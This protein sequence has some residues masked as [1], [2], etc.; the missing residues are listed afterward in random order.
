MADIIQL[1]IFLIVLIISIIFRKE[2]KKL[3][4]W[5]VSFRKVTKNEK[6]FS[7]NGYS[8]KEPK[9]I[10]PSKL[11]SKIAKTE[12]DEIKKDEKKFNF[13]EQY[14]LEQYDELI[15]KLDDLINMTD[16]NEQ[17]I[18]YKSQKCMVL[19]SV[20]R[21]KAKDYYIEL[22]KL[23]PTNY[24]PY[25]YYARAN[26][27]GDKTDECLSILE[28]GLQNVL[29]KA[30]L[31]TVKANCLVTIGD[32]ENAKKILKE[33]IQNNTD[34]PF[35]FQ[36]L[37]EI[38]DDKPQI[39]YDWFKIGVDKFPNDISLRENFAS[40]LEKN[41]LRGEALL[42]YDELSSRNPERA[43]YQASK[44]NNYLILG[45]YDKALESY[46]L[47]NKKAKEKEGW[48]IANIGNIYN[49]RGFYTQAAEYL[50]KALK[51]NPKSDYSHDRIASALKNSK[52]ETEK[53]TEVLAN[54]RK[55]S[56][57]KHTET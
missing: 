55:K 45:Y 11:E 7:L 9:K 56:T 39:A 29:E 13:Y 27:W 33:S 43:S 28:E 40:F 4:T 38:Y 47:A 32:L 36:K 1:I 16:D 10:E 19:F 17:L 18:K 25:D 49:N 22:K 57:F 44:G 2:I 42:Q 48:I 34:I 35:H 52:K 53:V 3:V 15:T 51:I 24:L 23:Y 12:T 46:L 26:Y 50:N 14:A 8:G 37:C 5:I 30:Q 6:G 31:I 41:E 20:D 21:K 54:A